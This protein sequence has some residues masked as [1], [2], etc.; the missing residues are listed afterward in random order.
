MAQPGE[1]LPL[2]RLRRD[3]TID[4]DLNDILEN[5]LMDSRER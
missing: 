5:S 3:L 1:Q 4:V 2:T